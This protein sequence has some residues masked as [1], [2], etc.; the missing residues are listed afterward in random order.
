MACSGTVL[1]ISDQMKEITVLNPTLAHAWPLVLGG[2]MA[3]D[4]FGKLMGWQI[5]APS[6]S[7]P[8][9]IGVQPVI[10]SA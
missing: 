6:D 5:P 8:A 3:L 1:A 2:S 7:A 4:R 10:K 9:A